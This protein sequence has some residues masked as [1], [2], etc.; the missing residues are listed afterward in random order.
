MRAV[1]ASIMDTLQ[2]WRR[3]GMYFIVI[4]EGFV[5]RKHEQT[6]LLVYVQ[7]K[8]FFFGDIRFVGFPPPP[9]IV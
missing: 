2:R 3:R 7:G 5:E 6:V 8:Y 1:S 4:G 9:N